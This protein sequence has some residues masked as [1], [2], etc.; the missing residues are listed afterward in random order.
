M[1]ELKA[2]RILFIV[3]REQIASQAKSS[4][5]RV[6]DRRITMGLLSGTNKEIDRDFIFSTMQTI[7]KDEYLRAFEKDHF[8]IIIVD[9]VHRA[10]AESYKR[11]MD[12]FTPGLW[13]GATASPYRSDGFDIFKLFDNNIAH[14]I[15]LKDALEDDLLC[16]FHYF[17]ISDFKEALSKEESLNKEILAANAVEEYRTKARGEDTSPKLRYF[18]RLE[19][20]AKADYIIEQ[21]EY[22]GFSGSRVK[23]LVFCSTI[24]EAAILSDQFNNRG[25]NTAYLTGADSIERRFDLVDRLVNDKNYDRLDYIFTVDIFNEGV[26][27]PEV[28]QIVMLRPTESPTIFIQQLGRG[29]RKYKDKEYVV[30]IDF[31]GNYDNNYMIPMALYGDRSY[32]KDNIR[33][34]L[35][36]GN[37][38]IPG[39]SSISFD[40]ISKERIYKSIDNANFSEIRLIKDNYNELRMKLGKIPSIMDFETHGSIDIQL[41]F[42]K[43]TL[44]SYHAFLSKYEKEY[45][46]KFTKDQ[47]LMLTFISTKFANAKRPHELLAIKYL[48][49]GKDQVL[50]LVGNALKSS[51]GLKYDSK[52]ENNLINILSGDFETGVA[53]KKFAPCILIE[54]YKGKYLISKSFRKML[55]DKNFKDQVMEL[56]DYGL[57]KYEKYYSNHYED[58]S[59]QLYSKYTY[60]DVCRLLNWDKN[61]VALNIGGYKYDKFTKTYPVFINY[62]KD[63][64]ISDTI[65]YEDRFLGND[66][67]I[68][69]SKSGRTADSD[70]VKTALNSEELGVDMHLFVRKNKDDKTS[71]EFYYLGKIFP[72]G[73]YKEFTMAD[74]RKTAVEIN[75]KL[76]KAIREDLYNYIIEIGE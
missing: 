33:K 74:T 49:E 29:L 55:E 17:G 48:L 16:T 73:E 61:E 64:D 66:S 47:E 6:F 70:D 8:D 76:D 56:V 44:G 5:E 1:R 58:T 12:Y 19:N 28:N 39:C 63:D 57:Y 21:I 54:K 20:T 50:D 31:I 22:Y 41:I 3:H 27:I 35:M 46:V 9:E 32:N 7:S 4:F 23:G 67:L 40:K 42:D 72:T 15:T 62:H 51:Y 52:V 14:E 65:K 43:S 25:Y 71:K 60:Y 69:I 30:I 24:E 26:D 10:G 75:Y 13:L 2:K 34:V 45:S 18:S 53:K 59:F 68:A 11:I 38:M 36:Q 37:R